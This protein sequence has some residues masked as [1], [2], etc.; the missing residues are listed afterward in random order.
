MPVQN[1]VT[2]IGDIEAVADRGTMMGNRGGCF[3]DGERCLLPRHWATRQWICCLLRFKDRHRRVMAPRRYT[4]LFFLDEATALAAGHRPCFECRRADA[5]HFAELW[6]VTLDDGRRPAAPQIDRRLHLERITGRSARTP[7]QVADLPPGA[8][9]ATDAGPALVI[10]GNRVLPWSHGGYRDPI[11]APESAAS[12][13]PPT[14]LAILLSGYR[15]MIHP[16]AFPHLPS[17]HAFRPVP[18][19]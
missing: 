6:S 9:I 11:Y 5:T 13:T 4:E 3:H 12:L 7:V 1:R 10:G 8:M 19:Q 15:P 16:S 14:M 2:P 18:A 17:A